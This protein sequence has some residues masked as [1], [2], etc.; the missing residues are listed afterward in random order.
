VFSMMPWEQEVGLNGLFTPDGNYFVAKGTEH[1]RSIFANG[2][3]VLFFASNGE[4]LWKFDAG[5]PFGL[6]DIWVSEGGEYIVSTHHEIGVT[7]TTYLIDKGGKV[8]QKWDRM[9]IGNAVFS[10]SNRYV[11][12]CDDSKI[13]LYRCNTGEPILQTYGDRWGFDISESGEVLALLR[14]RAKSRTEKDPI[15]R[16]SNGRVVLVDFRGEVIWETELPDVESLHNIQRNVSLSLN[17]RK[18]GVTLGPKYRVYH[19]TER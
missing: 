13:A 15:G 9:G 7:L 8:I 16:F 3:G 5:E 6:F 17:G 14:G 19:L 18:V 1:E 2:S 11:A 4:L 12:I 10:E